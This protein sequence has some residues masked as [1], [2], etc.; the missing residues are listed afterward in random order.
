MTVLL[1]RLARGE[2][3]AEAALFLLVESELRRLA[4]AQ[5][6]SQRADHTLQV[7]ALVNEAWMRLALPAARGMDGREHFLAVAARAMRCVLVDHARARNAAKRDGQRER[8]PLG[9]AVA[10]YED[11]ACDLVELD[12]ALQRLTERQPRQGKVVELRFFGGLSVDET[13]RVLG[14]A[15]ATVMRDWHLARIQLREELAP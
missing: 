5:L 7:T 4:S 13:A 8:L 6:G 2:P 14:V 10:F 9:E 1:Q 11:R 12:S 15:R 3:E